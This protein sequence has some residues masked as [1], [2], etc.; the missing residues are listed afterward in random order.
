M[1]AILN[2][3]SPALA[4]RTAVVFGGGLLTLLFAQGALYISSAPRADWNCLVA[5]FRS[6]ARRRHSRC[7]GAHRPFFP[8]HLAQST[9]GADFRRRGHHADALHAQ[10]DSRKRLA[11][12]GVV[13]LWCAQSWRAH[14]K[15]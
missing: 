9:G 13:L 14:S 3:L 8:G 4:G 10:R 5:F 1:Q 2:E 11:T 15:G 12:R 6:C 7:E